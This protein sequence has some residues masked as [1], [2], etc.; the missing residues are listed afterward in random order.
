M[1]SSGASG[2]AR[3]N[4]P[5]MVPEYEYNRVTNMHTIYT[6]R[7]ALYAATSLL[8]GSMLVLCYPDS[9]HGSVVTGPEAPTFRPGLARL[10]TMLPN[11]VFLCSQEPPMQRADSEMQIGTAAGSRGQL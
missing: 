2:T 5:D 1:E 10:N 7:D 8:I 3:E 9:V 6:S 4:L 11:C